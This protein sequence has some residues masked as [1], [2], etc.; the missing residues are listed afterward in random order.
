[1]NMLCLIAFLSADLKIEM[2]VSQSIFIVFI[3]A[4][5]LV[6]STLIAR[7][8]FMRKHLARQPIDILHQWRPLHWI[9]SE[10]VPWRSDRSHLSDD[11]WLR[12][13]PARLTL[14]QLEHDDTRGLA[15]RS[16]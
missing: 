14:P 10:F 16:V 12:V 4:K 5:T 7:G 1:M 3:V 11:G 2:K 8:W 13:G 6:L 15:D 9:G